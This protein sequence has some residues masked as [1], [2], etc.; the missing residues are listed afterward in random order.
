VCVRG[1]LSLRWCEEGCGEVRNVCGLLC[2]KLR[3]E[4]GISRASLGGAE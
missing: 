1:L 4:V 3:R 2:E